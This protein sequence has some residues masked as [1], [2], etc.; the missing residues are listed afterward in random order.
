[1]PRLELLTVGD[2]FQ[3]LIFSGLPRLPR[4]GEELR[5]GSFTSTVGGGA[6][7]TAAAAARLG[8]TAGVVSALSREGASIVR[9]YRVRV[10]NVR[11]AAEAHA[12]TVALS[13]TRERSFVTYDGVN[14]KLQSRLSAAIANRRA[15]HV[16]LAFS[17]Q[18]CSHWA[19]IVLRL[20]AR[21]TTTSLDVGWDPSLPRRRG[22]ARLMRSVD[23]VFMNRV[24]ASMISGIGR[25]DAAFWRR[26]A[27]N[28]VIK[29]GPRGCRWIGP[30]LDIRAVPP[31]VR[32][33]ETTGAGDAFN[34]GF[35][36]G[37]LR[38]LPPDECLRLA[39]AVGALST[40]APGGLAALPRSGELAS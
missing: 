3:D 31:R 5:T 39:N 18:R 21:G 32:V 19:A 33:V 37:I 29:L 22:F 13:T 14:A 38:G 17:P 12:V 6:V 1:V 10:V 27:R 16:H 4:A 15:L 9:Q 2:T 35:L 24:E 40:R 30:G 25:A 8:I 26:A 28:A 11:R 36:T 23:F 34:G 7:I 20:R